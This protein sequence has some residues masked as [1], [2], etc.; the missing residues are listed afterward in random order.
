MVSVGARVRVG[1]SAKAWRSSGSAK[2]GKIQVDRLGLGEASLD[3]EQGSCGNWN[4]LS[5]D[6][7]AGIPTGIQPSI[8][9]VD[10]RMVGKGEGEGEPVQN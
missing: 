6:P 1:D 10:R 5:G 4:C 9:Q 8:Q 7:A 2:R 3:L